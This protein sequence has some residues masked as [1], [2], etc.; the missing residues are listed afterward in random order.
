MPVRAQGLTGQRPAWTARLG[1]VSLACR[2]GHIFELV[3]AP[4][5]SAQLAALAARL[6]LA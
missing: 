1:K 4:V 3:V 5:P 2:N 6:P